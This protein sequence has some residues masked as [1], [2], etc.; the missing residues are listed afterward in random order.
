MLDIVE[1]LI[2]QP[3]VDFI[4]NFEEDDCYFKI[5]FFRA[6]ASWLGRPTSTL[7][8]GDDVKL[9]SIMDVVVELC[10]ELKTFFFLFIDMSYISQ[11]LHNTTE[12]V[13]QVD[14]VDGEDGGAGL[15][16]RGSCRIPW[17]VA[18]MCP[19]L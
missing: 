12:E 18:D 4:N 9:Q 11:S 1:M 8:T 10:E 5:Y 2:D 17:R 3:I 16:R 13:K 7:I 15:G 19:Q 14:I 6:S